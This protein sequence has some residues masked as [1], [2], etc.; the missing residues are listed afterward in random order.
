MP[1]PQQAPSSG[2]PIITRFIAGLVTNRNP[3]DTPFSIVGFNIVQHHDALYMGANME[4]SPQNTLVRRPGF[5]TFQ[6]LSVG[7]TAEDVFSYTDLE[8]N[9]SLFY[10]SGNALT[11]GSTVV[12][13]NSAGAG[14]WT[15][16]AAGN[17]LYATNGVD[18]VR[19]NNNALT[20]PQPWGVKPYN[21]PPQVTFTSLQQY[22]GI[23]GFIP[24]SDVVAGLIVVTDSAN[25]RIVSY[26]INTGTI[27]FNVTYTGNVINPNSAYTEVT[28][29]T[30]TGTPPNTDTTD[31]I[32]ITNTYT[33]TVT[34]TGLTNGVVNY[35]PNTGVSTIDFDIAYT[36][37]LTLSNLVS[38]LN[39]VA[40]TITTPG[41]FPSPSV[42]AFLNTPISSWTLVDG[43][44]AASLG[45]YPTI[46]AKAIQ[47]KSNPTT[48]KSITVN[49]GLYDVTNPQYSLAI[50]VGS[51]PRFY[52]YVSP[53]T[54]VTDTFTG[55]IVLTLWNGSLLTE[56]A[57]FTNATLQQVAT[58]INTVT[59]P[60]SP[61]QTNAY[62]VT[63]G[64]TQFLQ[65][66]SGVTPATSTAQD[67]VLSLGTVS[68][69][70]NADANLDFNFVP[71][72]TNANDVLPQQ[73]YQWAFA[74]R[75]TVSGA[76]GNMSPVV[77][78]AQQNISG[79]ANLTINIPQVPANYMVEV[80][81]TADGGSTLLFLG[82]AVWNLTSLVYTFIDI[83]PDSF[84]NAQLVG[85]IAEA[86]DPPPVG[87]SGVVSHQQRLWGFVLD[88]VYYAGGP[89]T[90]N[91]DGNQAWP[92]ANFF[93][94]PGNVVKLEPTDFG[95]VVVLKNDLHIILG[96]DTSSFYAKRWLVGYGAINRNASWVDADTLYIYTTKQQLF[97]L[98]RT[99]E[100]EI[101]FPIADQLQGAFPASVSNLTYHRN[102][103]LDEALY[104]SDGNI[105]IFRYDKRTKS[106]ATKARPLMGAGRVKSIE[107]AIGV[108]SLLNG[109]GQNWFVRNLSIFTD[110][111]VAY[112]CTAT[113]GILQVAT[114]GRWIT[115]D[116]IGIQTWAHGGSLPSIS[117]LNNE[118]TG[119]FISLFNPVPDPPDLYGIG[120]NIQFGPQTLLQ[121]R[122]YLKSSQVPL[123]M[124]MNTIQMTMAFPAEAFKAEVLGIA[125]NEQSRY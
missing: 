14:P 122:W 59:A 5:S 49:S 76:L 66:D 112:P 36:A 32:T 74:L 51:A 26:T 113:V 124:K 18:Q 91:G 31:V 87:L 107:S 57:T 125:F 81:R 117:L 101:G 65:I 80:Y 105:N 30:Q 62:V 78:L 97:A 61:N 108:Q 54:E 120:P 22:I 95:L 21:L 84:L 4:I 16:T 42:I 48:S 115:L 63:L 6:A 116:N 38:T 25:N 41:V 40:F 29:Q 82:Y 111:G 47:A 24:P 109:V 58:Q 100:Q 60:W 43:E 110:N 1:V 44:V 89:D 93:Q 104:I 19:I 75:E 67:I 34:G 20:T 13:A 15:V 39:G 88:K 114:P 69:V 11:L 17:F 27:H 2:L 103:S 73:Q 50:N 77:T 3:L 35:F 56:T 90:V 10:D 8:G 106:W 92:P 94:V 72:S 45:A 7:Q 121:Y 52:R 99:E 28:N 55:S 9:L 119:T 33:S 102:T 23:S 118:I 79:F 64:Q 85:P 12:K 68:V 70:D 86:N 96:V 37:P 123:P 71:L 98:G 46:P 83:F 53:L